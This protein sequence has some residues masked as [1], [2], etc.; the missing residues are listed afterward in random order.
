MVSQEEETLKMQ[1]E[2][3]QA[4]STLQAGLRGYSVRQGFQEMEEAAEIVQG[5]V[6]GTRVRNVQKAAKV[7][8]GGVRGSDER[9]NGAE[10]RFQEEFG[11]ETEEG[12]RKRE[13]AL[14]KLSKAQREAY[15]SPAIPNELLRKMFKILDPKATG[16][17]NMGDFLRGLK[18]FGKFSMAETTAFM[19]MMGVELSLIHI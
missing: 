17:V 16:C 1:E 3:E 2:M 12:I 9:R 14:G 6:A 4:G 13:Q 18:L 10:R 15:E 8:Q 11:G 7:V 19:K 5:G